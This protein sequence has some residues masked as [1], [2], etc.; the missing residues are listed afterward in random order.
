MA[1]LVV[2]TGLTAC[3]TPP[4]PPPGDPEHRVLV[5]GHGWH[6]GIVMPAQSAADHLPSLRALI[7]ASRW[8]EV[9]W[10]DARY[11]PAE[12]GTSGMAVS[13]LLGLNGS[14][15]HVVAFD[16]DPEALFAGL[17]RVEL[18]LSA[19]ALAA[20]ARFIS[21]GL[22]LDDQG[23]PVPVA[24]ARYATGAFLAST[25]P[26]HLFYTCNTWTADVLRHAGVP[27]GQPVVTA[28]SLLRDLHLIAGGSLRHSP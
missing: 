6:T 28:R 14:V 24:P 5:V 25:R 23:R 10:G 2:V 18:E 16:D 4:P 7:G 9:G 27:V 26:Y 22:Q 19:E 15:K 13:A 20:M 17:D 12:T 3:A 11:Y 1:A 8:L 21:A